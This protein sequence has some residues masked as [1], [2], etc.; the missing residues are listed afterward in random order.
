MSNGAKLTGYIRPGGEFASILVPIFATEGNRSDAFVQIVNSH[1][2]ISGFS[3]ISEVIK[4]KVVLH[5]SDLLCHPGEPAVYMISSI[6][7]RPLVYRSSDFTSGAYKVLMNR[8]I[9]NFARLEV[10]ILARNA[11]VIPH[12][13]NYI[14]KKHFKKDK[15]SGEFWRMQIAHT[16]CNFY[17]L[18]MSE[19]ENRDETE[20]KGTF[21][22]KRE[23]FVE[24]RSSIRNYV[25]FGSLPL[26]CKAAESELGKIAAL[27][28]WDDVLKEVGS[29]IDL[30][31]NID[32]KYIRKLL[33]NDVERGVAKDML[34]SSEDG[35]RRK[36]YQAFVSVRQRYVPMHKMI[37]GVN[38]IRSM[39]ALDIVDLA[40]KLMEESGQA[41][42]HDVS[43][44]ERLFSLLASLELLNKLAKSRAQ[45]RDELVVYSVS[46][47]S[48]ALLV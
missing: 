23:N 40:A 33:V 16:I 32:E 3:A 1:G 45:K 19:Y 44:S 14:E 11:T 25:E 9:D 21:R 17:R 35:S 46:Y 27:P 38:K 39:T 47:M 43:T 13:L 4:Q 6:S 37:A 31:K 42:P 7:G 28:D 5:Q 26:F 2:F 48:R 34:R 29:L 10:A 30:L 22:E 36:F 8:Q 18:E 12:L 20:E 41:L 15:E 24:L